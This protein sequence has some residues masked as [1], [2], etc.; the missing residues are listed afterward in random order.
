MDT[1]N[2][3][4]T[5]ILIILLSITM[6]IILFSILLYFKIINIDQIINN[7]NNLFNINNNNI[8]PV[9]NNIEIGNTPGFDYDSRKLKAKAF[10]LSIS[11]DE[12]KKHDNIFDKA[13]IVNEYGQNFLNRILYQKNT[14]EE[15]NN[16]LDPD[17]L[18]LLGYDKFVEDIISKGLDHISE[19]TGTI[20]NVI[21]NMKIIANDKYN[22]L[23]NQLNISFPSVIG[24]LNKE[25]DIEILK[26]IILEFINNN[27]NNF[28][29]EF[30]IKILTNANYNNFIDNYIFDQNYNEETMKSLIIELIINEYNLNILNIK[31]LLIE[32]Y[33]NIIKLLCTKL[34]SNF[35]ENTCTYDVNDCNNMYSSNN[36]YTKYTNN[37]C[38]TSSNSVL[39]KYVDTNVSNNDITYDNNNEKVKITS[40]YCRKKGLEETTDLEGNVDCK[41]KK[42]KSMLESAFGT[43]LLDTINKKYNTNDYEK[44][45]YNEIDGLNTNIIPNDLK[46]LIEPITKKY[47]PIEKSLCFDKNYDCPLNKELVN[48][49]CYNKCPDGYSENPDNKNECY[50]LYPYFEND[51]ELKNANFF[52]RKTIINDNILPQN[53]CENGYYYNDVEKKCIKNS[54]DGYTLTLYDNDNYLKDYPVK[55]DGILYHDKIIKNNLLIETKERVLK[56]LDANKPDLIDGK[57][58]AKCPDGHERL[59]GN[60]GTCVPEPCPSGYNKID[61]N[62]CFR[63]AGTTIAWYAKA[64]LIPRWKCPNNYTNIAGVCWA[65]S[66]PSGYWSS[67]PGFCTE[68][69]PTDYTYSGNVCYKCPEGYPDALGVQD[70]GGVCRKQCD[71]GYTNLIGAGTCWKDSCPDGWWLSSPG[72]CTENCPPGYQWGGGIC[73]KSCKP[74]DLAENKLGEGTKPEIEVGA[75]CREPCPPGHRDIAAVCYPDCPLDQRDDGTSC[76]IDIHTYNRNLT[77][78]AGYTRRSEFCYKDG[79]PSGYQELEYSCTR[80]SDTI[81]KDRANMWYGDCPSDYNKLLTTCSRG[82]HTIWKD[83]ANMWYGDCPSDYNTLATTCSRIASTHNKHTYSRVRGK[84]CC[85]HHWFGWRCHNECPSGYW[86]S[87]CECGKD[88]CDPG[89]TEYVWQ[90]CTKD[91]CPDGYGESTIGTCFRGAHDYN[92]DMLCPAGYERK[93]LYCYKIGCPDGYSATEFGSCFRGSHDYNRDMLC[94]AGFEVKGLYCY[95]IG[96]P[97]G[98]YSTEVGSCQRDVHTIWKD[99]V[100]VTR[101]ACKPY[102]DPSLYTCTKGATREPKKMVYPKTELRHTIVPKVEKLHSYTL[103]TKVKDNI[104]VNTIG[105]HTTPALCPSD[106]DTIDGSCYP[107]C[108]RDY[109][110]KTATTCET[111]S[112]PDNFVK[113]GAGTC[114]ISAHTIPNPQVEVEE[115]TLVCP[116]GTQEVLP[117]G[118]CYSNNTPEGYQRNPISIDE[119]I[120]K[121]PNDWPDSEKF[122]TRPTKPVVKVDATCPI[123]YTTSNHK[124]YNKLNCQSFE[125]INDK[126]VEKCPLDTV[127]NT[128]TKCGRKKIIINKE[129]K[130]IPYKYRLKKR[131]V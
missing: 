96:C 86:E 51:A 16:K 105:I 76:W 97:D 70:A 78:P 104:R 50:K 116:E 10:I 89:Y 15:I 22:L 41:F 11:A 128:D 75:L 56:C 4:D 46:Q 90:I 88:H 43:S 65:D 99:K 82:P 114:Q 94:P 48:G 112:C 63:N 36:I 25:I 19:S 30:N 38:L 34:R 91:G 109:Y 103:E 27:I 62:N 21:N 8:T 113:T 121:C 67:S 71:P 40:E 2:N 106:R 120:E 33:V 32:N 28:I 131:I 58:Y 39:Q 53:I 87:P 74:G 130:T 59:P 55:W 3:N 117:G 107:K 1:N 20:N 60:P 108:T 29:N 9:N 5:N 24:P 54:P 115:P 73:Y 125:S 64:P 81:W 77:C 61:Q 31:L 42:E 95:K 127:N 80:G 37:K 47:G 13:S 23:Y 12:L 17:D 68:N 66:C 44:C 110:S 124:C 84:G 122:C 102:Y 52:T 79:C 45:N 101:E 69:C 49:F 26:E 126:C 100:P 92:R 83:R 35:V 123:G 93:G 6:L 129:E 111:D 72:F 85:K 119:W 118:K 18:I 7:Y 14:I 57:C 98:Y